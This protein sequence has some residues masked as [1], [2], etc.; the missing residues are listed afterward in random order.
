MLTAEGRG[1]RGGAKRVDLRVWQTLAEPKHEELVRLAMAT[2]AKDVAAVSRLRKVCADAEIVRAALML[3]EARRKAI[4][5]FGKE[6]AA[7]LWADPAGVEMASSLVMAD[8]KATRF[9]VMLAQDAGCDLCCG[10]GGDAMM[11]APVLKLTA[12]DL[13]PVRAWMAGM[14]AG[15]ASVCADAT[16]MELP[17]GPVHIDPARREERGGRRLWDSAELR[18]GLS[19]VRAIMQRTR[20][21]GA[22]KLGPGADLSEIERELPGCQVEVISER[23]TLVQTVA[24]CGEHVMARPGEREAT[25]ITRRAGEEWSKE[26]SWTIAGVPESAELPVAEGN[27]AARCVYEP[28]D[29]VERVEL[30][31]TL[32]QQV[33][34]AMLHPR[35]GLLTSDTL[36]Q[37]PWLTGFEVLEEMVW[38]ERRV[39][40][41]LD[42]RRAGIVEVK[43]RGGAV[44][45]DQMQT[46]LRGKGDEPLVVFVL[47]MGSAMRGIIARR[48]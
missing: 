46:A 17:D 13:D 33:G 36:I 2:D 26:S 38:N 18:P 29:S 30:L 45:T 7:T 15:C 48:V 47:R 40:D 8:H 32:C 11:L 23:G 6:R 44:N 14:N 3:G 27:Q 42:A 21:G 5:K 16:A 34:A 28:D 19:D 41:A 4:P 39:K 12:V 24:W 10:I 35:V 43:T 31:G 25:L 22:V 37:S 1:E 9:D 20:W